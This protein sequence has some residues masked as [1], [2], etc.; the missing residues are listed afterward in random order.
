MEHK[1]HTSKKRATLSYQGRGL[2]VGIALGLIFG[3]MLDQIAVGLVLGIA[4]GLGV[5]RT[6]EQQAGK[7]DKQQDE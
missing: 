4:V 7:T 3:L 5:G 6:L 1:S 2:A